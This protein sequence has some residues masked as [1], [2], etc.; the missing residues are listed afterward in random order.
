MPAAGGT[1]TTPGLPPG[2]P[3]F[4]DT[5][6]DTSGNPLPGDQ[7]SGLAEGMFDY[8]EIIVPATNT[9]VLRTR[10]DAVSGNPTLYLRAGGLPTLSHSSG[11]N[12]GSTLYD[13]ALNASSGSQYGN[14]VPLDGRH[15]VYLSNGVWY[16]AVQASGGSNARYRLRM[17]TYHTPLQ[18]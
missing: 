11:G 1:V 5:G 17:D 15:Q 6:V 13:R 9:A 10:L 16:V 2:G 3:L 14:W 7:G 12:C 4:A 8:Y 18:R